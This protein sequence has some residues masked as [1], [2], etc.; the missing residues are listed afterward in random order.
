MKKIFVLLL[1][2]NLFACQNQ[3]VNLE[4]EKF[5]QINNTYIN[6]NNEIDAYYPTNSGR[7]WKYSLEQFQNDVPSTKF[8]KMEIS[9]ISNSKKSDHSESILNRYYPESNVQPYKTLVKKFSDRIELSRYVQK[10]VFK[11]FSKAGNDYITVLMSPL[12]I[13]KSWEGRLFQ[14]GKESIKVIGFEN[15]EVPAGKFKALKMNHHLKYDNGKEDNLYYWY[16]KDIGMIKMYEEITLVYSSGES[17]K[18][19]SIGSLTE[20]SKLNK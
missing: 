17:V 14:G 20:F 19:K 7:V 1:V 5:N 12:E 4:Q 10:E 3:V 15:I 18:F 11:E 9:V 13:N 6:S 2:T 8:S 16:T